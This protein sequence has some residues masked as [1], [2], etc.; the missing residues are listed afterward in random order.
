MAKNAGL[1]VL[2]FNETNTPLMN[3]T[4]PVSSGI[5]S[6]D[7]KKNLMPGYLQATSIDFGD[8]LSHQNVTVRVGIYHEGLFS[9]STTYEIIPVW[10]NSP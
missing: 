9:N 5:F 7:P 10:T 8:I 4:V 1:Q 2:A 3:V 6:T